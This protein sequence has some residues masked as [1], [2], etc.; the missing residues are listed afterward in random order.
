MLNRLC[1]AKSDSFSAPSNL[2]AVLHQQTIH[3]FRKP[4]GEIMGKVW[5]RSGKP[6]V[7]NFS[8]IWKHHSPQSAIL[9]VRT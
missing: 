3:G 5:K 9:D 6:E 4:L 1:C 7:A 8:E 2:A